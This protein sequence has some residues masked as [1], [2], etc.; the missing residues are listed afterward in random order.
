MGGE[1]AASVLATV[2]RDA[3]ESQGESWSAADEEAFKA[4]IREQYEEQG[5]P[6]YATARLWDDGVIDPKDTRSVLGLALS[7]CANAPL[8]PVG[9]GVFRMCSPMFST[10]LVANR[11]EI[12]VR[13]TRTLRRL[14][15]RSVV[16]YSDP[17]VDARHVHE[18]DLA[19][20]VG[21]AEAA[22]SYL[23]RRRD[24][25]CRPVSGGGRG[26][27][28]LRLP[29]RE[30]GL[31]ARLRSRPVWSSSVPLR[32]RSRRW[33]TRSAR[34][35]PSRPP[36][37]PSSPDSIVPGLTD[38]G[39]RGCCREHRLPGAPQAL[40][41]RWRQGH[42]PRRRAWTGCPRR[43]R[44]RVAKR[45]RPSATTPCSSSASSTGPGTSRS[46]CWPTPTAASF[47]WGSASAACSAGTRRSS[48][49]RR[50]PCSRTR[51]RA[52]IGASAVR[53]AQACGYVGAGTVEFIV[54]GD[55][56]DDFY[57]MEMNT[58]LQV[59][60]PVTELVTGI[61]LVEQQLRVAS[62]EAL[63]WGQDDLQLTGHAVE[64]RVYAEDP[65]RDFLP[66]GGTVLRL[67]EPAGDHVRV[68][69]GIS[70]GLGGRI[71]L[72]PHA[73]Q[74]HRLGRRPGRGSGEA[75][76]RSRRDRR[77]G[78][79]TRT[80]RSSVR[81]WRMPTYAPDGWTPASSSDGWPTSSG[82][83]CR[84][85]FFVPQFSPGWSSAPVT[86]LSDDPFETLA[87][88]RLGG[89]AWVEHH[90]SDGPRSGSTVSVRG[91]AASAEV[92]GG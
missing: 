85:R 86:G 76:V 22:L 58:R 87:D 39:P 63:P 35:R 83:T 38:D 91:S 30:R 24:R 47:T 74:D 4:P 75:R 29:R 90:L 77:A 49:R 89:P 41:G 53:T 72:R 36:V 61:D 5:N 40:R 14:G 18:A 67:R 62:G 82:P 68:D 23:V 59:E 33:A 73:R 84:T 2:R 81:C 9:Y 79:R 52:S 80:W 28:G 48:R 34:S 44:R 70:D 32:R 65:A 66:T 54:A 19:V 55:A 8:E 60:H 11:G 10:V 51:R 69:S 12:A 1:Q 26:A 6:Y 3:L 57:F 78:R 17:D 88:W 16:V 21:P 27:P 25:G 56:P 45:V 43:S 7:T 31:R 92:S 46:R 64:A 15:V 37:S 50:R 71:Q 13:I 20:R 42:A